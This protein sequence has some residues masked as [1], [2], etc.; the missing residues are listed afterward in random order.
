MTIGEPQDSFYDATTLYGMAQ[1]ANG[2][3]CSMAVVDILVLEQRMPVTGRVAE[4]YGEVTDPEYHLG[5]SQFINVQEPRRRSFRQLAKMMVGFPPERGPDTRFK[6]LASGIHL[7]SGLEVELGMNA[8]VLGA[9]TQEAT[10]VPLVDF[11]DARQ[12]NDILCSSATL[13][14]GALLDPSGINE[15]S[16]I[17]DEKTPVI[18][19]K[20]EQGYVLAISV[21]RDIATLQ[22]DA[23]PGGEPKTP[24][25]R[26]KHTMAVGRLVDCLGVGVGVADAFDL[27][28]NR[29]YTEEQLLRIKVG[30][31]IGGLRKISRV[32]PNT[33]TIAVE[34]IEHEE[35][36]SQNATITTKLDLENPDT[37]IVTQN[38]LYAT[39]RPD[40]RDIPTLSL[41]LGG[42]LGEAVVETCVTGEHDV[43][44]IAANIID[45]IDA[46]L[47]ALPTAARRDATLSRVGR[48]ASGANQEYQ[49]WSEMPREY[50][51]RA[52][53]AIDVLANKFG[54]AREDF[55]VVR[56]GT[57]YDNEVQYVAVYAERNLR[58]LKYDD[59]VRQHYR[60]IKDG[61]S[62]PHQDLYVE[63]DG[64]P[65]NVLDAMNEDVMLALRDAL[66]RK[67]GRTDIKL[68]RTW[69]GVGWDGRKDIK[70]VQSCSARSQKDDVNKIEFHDLSRPDTY[71]RISV[72]P[73]VVVAARP[74]KKKPVGSTTG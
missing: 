18:A 46:S 8:G 51:E 39:G 68:G 2:G 4:T 32:L 73:A 33:Y 58:G 55:I 26:A 14:H 69:M 22:A 62:Q 20:S 29:T 24:E 13:R 34:K 72:R 19:E 7:E 23:V 27:A 70:A 25:E 43:E 53:L 28:S 63:L 71:G 47:V 45:V 66:E 56:V 11:H 1:E 74:G 67:T 41:R 49:D 44:P 30:R 37:P 54:V 17:I 10:F 31:I 16:T 6:R 50:H 64:K 21:L 52:S 9:L 48:L 5:V 35:T 65:V 12:H 38:V 3:V 61:F 57:E 42:R 60:R 36:P 15:I 40:R 59:M